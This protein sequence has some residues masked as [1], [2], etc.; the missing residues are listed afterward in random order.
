MAAQ[1]RRWLSSKRVCGNY[2][3]SNTPGLVLLNL[4]LYP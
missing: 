2:Y 1:F 4:Q 3:L